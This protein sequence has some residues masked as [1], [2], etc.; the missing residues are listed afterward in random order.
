MVVNVKVE[1]V[2]VVF[3]TDD[4]VEVV[5][6]CDVEVLVMVEEVEVVRVTW[7]RGPGE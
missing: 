4:E 6:V 2:L 3:V 1:E 5:T 7:Q